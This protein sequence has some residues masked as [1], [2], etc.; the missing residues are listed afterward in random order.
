[1]GGGLAVWIF[2]VALAGW[3]GSRRSDHM[4]K[5]MLL[6]LLAA[7]AIIAF[8]FG[9]VS[10]QPALGFPIQIFWILGPFIL[11]IPAIAYAVRESQK[12]RDPV[13]PTPTECWKGGMIYS[14]PDDAALFVQRRDSI[15]F[16]LNLANRWSWL[17]LGALAL[18]LVSAVFVLP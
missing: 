13:D 8:L 16:T 6:V 5:P 17:L 10:L 15:G 4:R 3:Y 7:E 14:N 1:M 18:I 2:A 11:L 9:Q 12:A